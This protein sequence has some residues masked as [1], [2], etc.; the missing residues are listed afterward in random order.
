MSK[1]KLTAK[2]IVFDRC[3]L[4]KK[5]SIKESSEVAKVSH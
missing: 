1:Q 2:A 3:P 4:K 5:F